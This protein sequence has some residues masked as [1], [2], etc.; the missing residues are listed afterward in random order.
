[1]AHFNLG[2]AFVAVGRD[3]DAMEQYRHALQI[4]PGAFVAR[5]NLSILTFQG[6]TVFRRDRTAEAMSAGEA[7]NDPAS[8][9]LWSST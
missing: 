1:M 4:D 9:A 3:A 2:L 6:G 7:G 5:A 8:T